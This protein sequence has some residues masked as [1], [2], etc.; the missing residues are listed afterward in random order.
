MVNERAKPVEPLS[1]RTDGLADISRSEFV[2]A[3]KALVGEPPATMLAN[4]SEM[5]RILVDS[6]PIAGPP[7]MNGSGR[8]DR[9]A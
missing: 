4:R 7:E 8:D 5:I 3:W 6:T 2:A 9:G 1:L